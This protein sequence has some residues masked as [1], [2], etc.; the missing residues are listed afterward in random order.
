MAILLPFIPTIKAKVTAI[1]QHGDKLYVGLA[2]GAL[3]LYAY[4]KGHLL[5]TLSPARRQIDR[6][7]VLSQ[8][9]LL[10]V[11]SDATVTLYDL[12]SLEKSTITLLQA[13]TV[14]SF[15]TVVYRRLERL[16]DLL[17]VGCRK[18]V[19]VYGAGRDGLK[20]GWEL[21]IPHSPRHIVIPDA[22]SDL[23][24]TIHLLFTTSTSALLHLN[25]SSSRLSM[26]DLTTD[27]PPPQSLVEEALAQPGGNAFGKGAFG[28]LGGYVGLGGRSVGPVGTETVGGEV[29]LARDELGVF[30]STKGDYTRQRSIHWG[31]P[32]NGIGFVNPYIYTLLPPTTPV[33]APSL[34]IHLASTLTLCSTLSLPIQLAGSLTPSSLTLVSLP[35][36]ATA[37][38]IKSR[39][40][41]LF[42]TTPTDKQLLA[43]EGSSIWAVQEK[44][45]QDEVDNLVREGRIEDAIG[46][47]EAIG[48]D[49]LSLNQRLDHLKI[50][51]AVHQM[52]RGEYQIAMETFLIHNVNPALVLS[53]YPASTISGKLHVPRLGWLEMFGAVEGAKL[54]PIAVSQKEQEDANGL[55][56]S[57]RA[58]AL[59][60]RDGRDEEN[61]QCA[62]N[63]ESTVVHNLIETHGEDLVSKEAFEA[64]M[65]FLSD[66]RQKLTGAISSS[67]YSLPS[68]ASLPPLSSLSASEQRALPSLPFNE[69]ENGQQLLR[70]AQIIY[71]GLIKVYLVARPV[72][73]GSLCRIENWCDVQEVEGLLK[74]KK[75]FG[76]LIDLYQGKKMHKKALTRLAKEEDDP[77]DRYPPTISY[78]H[79]LGPDYL[80]L[81]LESSKWIFQEAPS[82]ALSAS[83]FTADELEVDLLP[84]DK[85][86][87][88]LEQKFPESCMKYLEHLIYNM[89][90]K[91][92]DYHDKLACFLLAD[93]RKKIQGMSPFHDNDMITYVLYPLGKVSESYDKFLQFLIFSSHYRPY[94]L[95]N[96]LKGD[97][98][99]EAR[100]IL[101]GRMGKHEEALKIY[102]Y[103]LE[104]YY[105]AESYCM[106][107]YPDKSDIFLILL[108][109]YLRPSSANHVHL[110]APALS[111]VS[112]HST[113]LPPFSVLN[114]L[115]PLVGL[116]DVSQFFIR[117]IREQ[118]RKRVEGRVVRQ[119]GRARK[120]QVNAGLMRLD[121]KRVRVTDQ[122]IC[123]QC[124][125]RLGM[126]A[127]AVHTP[128]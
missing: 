12:D 25:P 40:R 19:V 59:D 24:E 113:S 60:K 55:L 83:I 20:E 105:A 85:I 112:K 61:T 44:D 63:S 124:H 62:K 86:T 100:A 81:I 16:C 56:E 42:V 10:V 73:V 80:D 92:V 111:L 33:S 108:Q 98:M 117:T 65:Y 104:D 50:L 71:T 11:L 31:A 68:E 88:F 127:I 7:G 34:Q 13:R 97:E 3:Q 37:E 96:Q 28:S 30:Y 82:Q 48:E 121:T 69:L 91:G 74:E 118:F 5:S 103:K 17:V 32:P 54:Y 116:T 95:M 102:V 107:T 4:P 26:T 125:K 29:L 120:E 9:K 15:A 51:Q 110:L 2:N 52:A 53:L 78:L 35:L 66:R 27:P 8:A 106:R 23:P 67:S 47:V 99:P 49:S 18:K 123:P 14:Y 1:H 21:A 115:P 36:L 72:L 114:L 122:R 58:I 64:L 75:K 38:N 76:D 39:I 101:L 94:R 93:S 43:S 22:G 119:I 84:R 57:I 77:L 90:E 89:G 6:I 70:M 45:L 109:L 41:V 79:K 46:L 128:R 126:S 87:A